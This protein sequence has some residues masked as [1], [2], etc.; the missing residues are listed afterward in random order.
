MPSSHVKMLKMLSI[1]IHGRPSSRALQARF[2]TDYFL[3]LLSFSVPSSWLKPPSNTSC[4]CTQLG[5]HSATYKHEW[6]TGI[7]SDYIRFSCFL[8]SFGCS[9]IAAVV[10]VFTSVLPYICNAFL[11]SL[12]SKARGTNEG[13]V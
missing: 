2:R 1:T 5:G 6:V 12:H 11:E 13:V 4:T 8:L 3:R 7:L 10:I 9:H